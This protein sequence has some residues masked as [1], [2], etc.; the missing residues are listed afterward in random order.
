MNKKESVKNN[1]RENFPILG[2]ILGLL[3]IISA[4]LVVFYIFRKRDS[5]QIPTNFSENLEL[6]DRQKKIFS[7]LKEKGELRVD[8]IMSQIGGVSERTLRRDMSKLED[9]GYSKKLGSTKG[10]KYIF[11]S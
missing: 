10:A 7:L 6:N 5:V 2:F 1:T 3:S 4:F 11:I 9:L 8:D